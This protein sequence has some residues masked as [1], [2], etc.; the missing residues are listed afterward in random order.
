MP[1]FSQTSKDRLATCHPKL[2]EVLNEVIKYYDI[3]IAC[4][5]RGQEEQDEAYAT[6]KSKLQYPES[7]HNEEP[8]MAADVWMYPVDWDNTNEWY[9]MAGIVKGIAW[10]KGVELEWGGSYESFFDGPHFSLILNE[11][12]N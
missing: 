4:G 9:Y 10:T 5:H 2:Q 11:S 6:G 3:T 8:S 1:S 7:D 12:S